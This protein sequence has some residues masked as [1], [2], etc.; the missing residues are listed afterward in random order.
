MSLT[1]AAVASSPREVAVPDVSGG[2]QHRSPSR[3]LRGTALSMSGQWRDDGWSMCQ[4]PGVGEASASTHQCAGEHDGPQHP[5]MRHRV[6]CLPR[7]GAETART[8]TRMEDYIGADRPLGD[9]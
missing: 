9:G 3:R 6:R 8:E 4:L 5:E 7:P 2:D 1:S